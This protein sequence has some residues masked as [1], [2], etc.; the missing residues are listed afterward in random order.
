MCSQDL[1]F[2]QYNPHVGNVTE[3]GFGRYTFSRPLSICTKMAT[4]GLMFSQ[5][6]YQLLSFGHGRKLESFGG[7]IVDRPC[8]AA[9][10]ENWGDSDLDWDEHAESS[11]LSAVE[12]D[13]R[14]EGR[15][16][17]GTWHGDQKA[18]PWRCRYELQDGKT[19]EFELAATPTGQ[20][21]LFP[22]QSANWDWIAKRCGAHGKQ[23]GRATKVLNLFAYTGGSTLAAA[24][25]GA[26]VT[27]VDAAKSVV[28][29]ARRNAEHSGLAEAPIRWIVEDAQKFVA[30]EL[31]RGNRYDG[32]ILDPPSYGHGPKREEW[33]LAR[34]LVGLVDDCKKLLSEMPAFFLLSCHTPGYGEPELGAALTT[35]LFG[36]CGA[37]VQTR[38]LDL[39]SQDGP[40]L[41]AG[42][43][44]F[45]P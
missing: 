13:L 4:I 29:W 7:C 33:K 22:E 34:D 16:G 27:H 6:N 43:A 2:S 24:A 25:M 32:V 21:G 30:R 40:R 15:T 1:E 18:D 12:A 44:A 19:I 8:P 38:R 3:F 14:F 39:V 11:S 10:A 45:W 42:H 31:K 9:E 36:R 5:E 17:K 37:G 41:S 20:V 26:E 35:A 28:T 23:H